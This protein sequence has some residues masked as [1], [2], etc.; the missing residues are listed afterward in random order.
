MGSPVYCGWY[1]S[2]A[3]ILDLIDEERMLRTSHP[4]LLSDCVW[5]VPICLRLL[6]PSQ[7]PIPSCLPPTALCLHSILSLG[8]NA[9]WSKLV[10]GRL[11]V[12][13]VFSFIA[14]QLQKNR[15]LLRVIYQWDGLIAQMEPQALGKNMCQAVERGRERWGKRENAF[16][17]ELV[18][19]AKNLNLLDYFI[20]F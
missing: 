11:C 12:G 16:Q 1:H 17:N 2:L 8:Y 13:Y 6:P 9:S 5:N 15:D 18:I 19:M 10:S 14:F 4:S 20:I 7:R 3:G